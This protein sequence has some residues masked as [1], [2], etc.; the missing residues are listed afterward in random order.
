MRATLSDGRG[1]RVLADSD[2]P[3]LLGGP[4]TGVLIPGRAAGSGPVGLLAVEAD[5]LFIQPI[6]VGESA[7]SVN[8]S[9][10]KEARWLQNGDVIM[11]DGVAI[12]ISFT[13]E[14]C[15]IAVSGVGGDPDT[16]PPLADRLPQPAAHQPTKG[17]RVRPVAYQPSLQKSRSESRIRRPWLWF[18]SLIVLVVLCSAAVIVLSLRAISVETTPG[19]EWTTIDGRWPAVHFGDEFLVL[20]GRY[21]LVAGLTNHEDLVMQIEVGR[22]NEAIIR[23]EFIPLPGRLSVRAE[24]VVGADVLLDGVHV[25]TTPVNDAEVMLGEHRVEVLANRHQPFSMMIEVLNPAQIIDIDANLVE[26]WAPLTIRSEPSGAKISLDGQIVGLTP[27]TIEAGAGSRLVSLTRGGF[28]RHQQRVTVVAGKAAEIEVSLR[29]AP[30]V[31]LLQTLPSGA[32][33][34]VDGAFRGVSPMELQVSPGKEHTIQANL[35]GHEQGVAQIT[36]Q[37]GG[38]KEL[39]LELKPRLGRIELLDIPEGSV[40]TVDGERVNAADGLVDLLAVPHVIEVSRATG[41]SFRV[42]VLPQPGSTQ[43]VRVKHDVEPLPEPPAEEVAMTHDAKLRLIRPGRFTM[44]APRREPGRRANEILRDVEITRSYYLGI[45]E[46]TNR[47]YREFNSAHLSGKIGNSNLEID[48]HPVVRVSWSDAARY[49][50]WLSERDG[51]DPVYAESNG[52]MVAISPVPNGFRLPTEAEWAWAARHPGGGEDR[53]YGWGD[54]LPIPKGAG[55]F[56]DA[57]AE[58]LLG[59]VITSYRDGAVATAPAGSFDPNEVGVFNLAGN[60]AEW[61]HDIYEVRVPT[62]GVVEKDPTGPVKGEYHVIRGASYMSDRVTELRLS[63][64]DSGKDKRPDLGFRVAR[65][66]D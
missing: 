2:F 53:K 21:Q 10:L 14:E 39:K 12:D 24:G 41:E 46:V 26:S 32:T 37:A 31:V 19:A 27:A 58:P 1:H 57:E 49:C 55:N 17:D 13:A 11:V 29:R 22:G 3:L 54:Q 42:E 16:N 8:G 64:R 15:S 61:V 28:Q 44:G 48:H 59:E 4:E 40:V 51:L 7:I 43:T 66:A 6:G 9:A 38:R 62:A 33:L 23:A 47:E 63:L 65:F 36:V 45:R 18:F 25:G 60:V 56:G 20:P 50:N 34:S 52:R 5:G 30:A 35:A